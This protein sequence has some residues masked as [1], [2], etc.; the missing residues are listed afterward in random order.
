MI[1]VVGG[2]CV[3]SGCVWERGGECGVVEWRELGR[4][5]FAEESVECSGN[6]CCSKTLSLF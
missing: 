4:Q 5:V 1:R 3:F 2:E 6:V